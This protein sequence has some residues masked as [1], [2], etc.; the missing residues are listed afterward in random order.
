MKTKTKTKYTK[1]DIGLVVELTN[2]DKSG[3]FGAGL[4]KIKDVDNDSIKAIT[5]EPLN[6]LSKEKKEKTYLD[7]TG[8]VGTPHGYTHITNEYPEDEFMEYYL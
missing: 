7:I 6:D 1:E 2:V 3:P 4:F 8:R 5:L